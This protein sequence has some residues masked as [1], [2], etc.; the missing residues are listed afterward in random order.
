MLS[1]DLAACS[2][3]ERETGCVGGNAS[4][5]AT[6]RGGV[7]SGAAATTSGFAAGSGG[8]ACGA[9]SLTTG[10]LTDVSPVNGFLY[11]LC[12]LITSTDVGL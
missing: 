6:G 11:S 3:A 7:G 2:S 12:D 8:A 1:S 9:G 5:R 4:A 10:E